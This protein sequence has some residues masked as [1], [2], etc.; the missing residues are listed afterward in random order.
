MK[1]LIKIASLIL[2]LGFSFSL[3]NAASLDEVSGLGGI[4]KDEMKKINQN[5]GVSE[6]K[7]YD[8]ILEK[9]GLDKVQVRISKEVVDRQSKDEAVKA[10][11]EK[12]LE[13]GLK[14]LLTD[15][16]NDGSLAR[17]ALV[18]THEE[19]KAARA[20]VEM[21]NKPGS[22]LKLFSKRADKGESPAANWIFYLYAPNIGNN[23]F[24]VIV[25]KAGK[26]L[27]YNYAALAIHEGEDDGSQ[28]DSPEIPVVEGGLKPEG[29]I[30]GSRGEAGVV[31]AGSGASAD[32]E[33]MLRQGRV[34]YEN[35]GA[36]LTMVKY[37]GWPGNIPIYGEFSEP[38]RNYL[39]NTRKID[40]LRIDIR[41][42]WVKLNE[43]L[44][45]N[46]ARQI[47]DEMKT[48]GREYD[49][50]V[51][52]CIK[53]VR[54]G[55]Q[56]YAE[57]KATFPSVLH[58]IKLVKGSTYID[59]YDD[60]GKLITRKKCVRWETRYSFW[61]AFTSFYGLGGSPYEIVCAEYKE[62]PVR[63]K[64]PDYYLEYSYEGD[65]VYP[66]RA[67]MIDI[68]PTPAFPEVFVNKSLKR[69]QYDM[70]VTI[71]C[72][73][74]KDS[75]KGWLI[76]KARL[77]K[78]KAMS[79]DSLG[80]GVTVGGKVGMLLVA[81]GSINVNINYSHT[82]SHFRF[83]EMVEFPEFVGQPCFELGRG[84]ITKNDKKK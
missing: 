6:W 54:Q 32:M 63:A 8:H 83:G 60:N 7:P 11:F 33:S 42:K 66:Q 15:S 27:P 39:A 16:R 5:I 12:A 78:G 50:L 75:A 21:I 26:N 52:E 48:M 73:L 81:E 69:D 10:P 38:Y 56:L 4:S 67:R 72:A 71:T 1:S 49:M 47:V 77:R 35:Y 53:H 76:T 58:N 40:G 18:K 61:G 70:E 46:E 28:V 44:S 74:D 68:P 31:K 82:W 9:L 22:S 30:F 19:E 59:L 25:D 3:L 55:Q 13:D 62:V 51:R 34:L 45:L 24:F 20:A 36:E 80:G 84:R 64:V 65:Q 23:G 79:S 57:G 29:D 14:N 17:M 43:D 41:A 2:T 37:D